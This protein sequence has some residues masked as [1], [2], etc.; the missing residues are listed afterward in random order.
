MVKLLWAA[1]TTCTELVLGATTYAVT[2]RTATSQGIQNRLTQLKLYTPAEGL[3][4]EQELYRAA[5]HVAQLPRELRLYLNVPELVIY[6]RGGF[7]AALVWGLLPT[8][9]RM[10]RV[11]MLDYVFIVCLLAEAVDPDSEAD[12]LSQVFRLHKFLTPEG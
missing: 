10:G 5:E 3:A 7:E 1:H 6:K 11:P 9:G 12:V 2:I 8:G 4:I